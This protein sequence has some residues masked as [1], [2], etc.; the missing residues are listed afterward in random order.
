MQVIVGTIYKEMQLKPSYF[1][2]VE[3]ILAPHLCRLERDDEQ[4]LAHGR[5]LCRGRDGQTQGQFA[6]H[7]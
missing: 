2:A 4:I 5:P 7:C 3:S 1:T 6:P